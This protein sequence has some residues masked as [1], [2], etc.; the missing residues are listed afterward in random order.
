[1]LARKHFIKKSCN[2]CH[3]SQTNG[4]IIDTRSQTD[5]CG[6]CV[7]NSFLLCNECLK[8]EV[9]VVQGNLQGALT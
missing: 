8:T 1:M 4:V 7:S 9:R 5:S 2:E 3:K 6:L